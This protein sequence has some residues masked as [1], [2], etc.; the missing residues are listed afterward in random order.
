M[1]KIYKQCL[2]ASFL[3]VGLLPSVQADVMYEITVI[4]L[5]KGQILSPIIGNISYLNLESP[6][7]K[8]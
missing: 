1:K 3:C 4:N 5:T 7:V 6:P 8:N 2:I